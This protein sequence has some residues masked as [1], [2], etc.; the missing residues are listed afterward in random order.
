LAQEYHP[1]KNSSPEAKEKFTQINKYF[2]SYIAHTKFYQIHPKD[3][4]TIKLDKQVRV[5]LRVTIILMVVVALVRKTFSINSK[6]F[7]VGAT[8]VD[9]RIF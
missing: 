5:T 4:S 6:D 1:D 9:S 8:Q 3:S 7:K 2:T